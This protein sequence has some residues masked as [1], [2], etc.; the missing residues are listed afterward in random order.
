LGVRR[1]LTADDA[2][3]N[4]LKA[5]RKV[6]VLFLYLRYLRHLRLENAQKKEQEGS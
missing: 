3:E 1:Q 4:R 6:G 5:D 2:D